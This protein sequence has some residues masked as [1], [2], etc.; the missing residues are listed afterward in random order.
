MKFGERLKKLRE[1]YALSGYK[2]GILTNRPRQF[3]SNIENGH[4]PPPDS[5][6][7]SLAEVELLQ[8][9]YDELK[10]WALEDKYTR[11]Q[12]DLARKNFCNDDNI[13]QTRIPLIK[14]CP[15]GKLFKDHA[16][17]DNYIVDWI[18]TRCNVSENAFAIQISDNTMAPKIEPGDIAI[19]EPVKADELKNN[20]IYI[21]QNLNNDI[22]A[23]IVQ[24]MRKSV[25]LY[26]INH[27]DFH[28]E[29][30]DISKHYLLGQAIEIIKSNLYISEVEIESLKK[31]L[32]KTNLLD[33]NSR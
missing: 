15:F 32:I 19:I 20:Y 9:D 17:N 24:V 27:N 23:R 13:K 2:L 16:V 21:F 8:V 1:N 4:R 29:N 33:I 25:S 12:I 22:L 5:F 6:L 26:S 28:F 18:T 31:R 30:Y 3:I 10:A 11:A 14:E 7:K